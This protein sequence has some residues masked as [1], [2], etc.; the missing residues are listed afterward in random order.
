[1]LLDPAASTD[2]T[3]YLMVEKTEEIAAF[4]QQQEEEKT[5]S[6]RYSAGEISLEE[7]RKTEVASKDGLKLRRDK[8]LA[9]AR[10]A[11]KLVPA[12]E[13]YTLNLAPGLMQ[14]GWEGHQVMGDVLAKLRKAVD[15]HLAAT[16]AAD[17]R[18]P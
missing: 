6:Q 11:R 2:G 17:T 15:S 1:M 5:L 3:P 8:E 4:N 13:R 7:S 14:A 16:G 9:E 12:P 18:D 10:T